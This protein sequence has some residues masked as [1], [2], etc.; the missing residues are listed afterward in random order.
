MK[1]SLA[2]IDHFVA[3]ITSPHIVQDLPFGER[4]ITLS[5]KE[6]VKVPN[7]VRMLIP[8][9]IVKQYTTYCQE[10][11]FKPLSRSTLLRILNV[12]AAS[13]RTS[14]QGIDYVSSAGA[15]AFDELGDAGQGMTWA[16]LQ[17]NNLRASKRYLKSDYKVRGFF[18]RLFYHVSYP[19][20]RVLFLMSRFRQGRALRDEILPSKLY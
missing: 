18:V 9:R 20:R 17:E 15:E 14:L 4:G 1:V 13:V 10:S 12:C 19:A 3:F 11:Q 6:T 5:T 8:E 7:V 2:Q 16:K